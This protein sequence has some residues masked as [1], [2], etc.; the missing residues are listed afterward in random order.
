MTRLLLL[1]GCAAVLFAAKPWKDKKPAEW[2]TEDARRI[3]TDSPWA[4]TASPEFSGP[5][6]GGG[7]GR[8]GMDGPGVGRP[9]GMGGPVGGGIGG[10]GFPGGMGGSR[11][12]WGGNR[13][14]MGG[15]EIPTERPA[16]RVRWESAAPVREASARLE[17]ANNAKIAE[18]AKDYYVI[19]VSGN[20]GPRVRQ[21]GRRGSDR[22]QIDSSQM[23]ERI[24][25]ATSLTFHG[26]ER[27]CP[28]KMERLETAEGTMTLFLFPRDRDITA[29]DKDVLFETS[30]GPMAVKAKFKIKD[31]D[32]DGRP[33]L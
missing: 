29:G 15:P 20:R 9:G 6:M 18:F 31:M 27:M 1:T 16:I 33:A 24:L 13:G 7:S 19:S 22:P 12:G 4:K 28:A 11:G 25:E 5:R 8:P 21:G 30:L 14:G 23:Q 3:L 2:T 32:L 10:T 26:K 17:I